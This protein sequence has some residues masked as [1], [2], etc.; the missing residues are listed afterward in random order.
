M[1]RSLAE[2]VR[3]AGLIRPQKTPWEIFHYME[4]NNLSSVPASLDYRDQRP[5]CQSY[6]SV[7][8]SWGW[9][10]QLLEIFTAIAT[11]LQLH[12]RNLVLSDFVLTRLSGTFPRL[13][14]IPR[15]S[16]VGT[17]P[18]HQVT[19]YNHLHFQAPCQMSKYVIGTPWP[20]EL[21]NATTNVVVRRFAENGRKVAK[22]RKEI[23]YFFAFNASL[24][25]MIRKV[26]ERV[27][28]DRCV[29]MG[30][31]WDR[32]R[33]SCDTPLHMIGIQVRRTDYVFHHRG[34]G[35]VMVTQWYF[36]KAMDVMRMRFGRGC[37]FIVATDEPLWVYEH[38]GSFPDVYYTT[39][40][41]DPN[42]KSY[43]FDFAAVALSDHAITR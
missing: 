31:H 22:F 6:V 9:G 43:I 37:V 7:Y 13:R 12:K 18:I 19:L 15:Y 20:P 8:S 10:N 26:Y 28:L 5:E 23:L 30:W 14:C 36:F 1:H 38:F 24:S 34:L 2:Q 40:F 3:L 16:E 25:T 32:S 39:D 33:G 29:K 27:K 4:M 35:G 17:S 21:F 41:R 11:A 42:V